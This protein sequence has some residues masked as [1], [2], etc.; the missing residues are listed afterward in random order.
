MYMYVCVC[1]VVEILFVIIV[2][3]NTDCMLNKRLSQSLDW[4]QRIN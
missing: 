3:M 2:R 4:V 1:S